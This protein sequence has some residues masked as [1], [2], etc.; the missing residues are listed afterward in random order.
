MYQG[1]LLSFFGCFLGI[2]L[3]VIIVLLQQKFELWMLSPSLPYPVSFSF[4]NIAVVFATIMLLSYIASK[5]ASSRV[6]EKLF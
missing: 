6:S 2:L 4:E 5:I 1:L 3:G